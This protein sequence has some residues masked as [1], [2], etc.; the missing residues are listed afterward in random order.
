M[1]L[2]APPALFRHFHRMAWLAALFTASTILFGS[3]VRL[4][5]AGMSC[6]DWPTCYGRVT[7]PQTTNEANTHVA[8]KIRPLESHKAWREQ[9]HRFLAGA[10]GVE[11]LVLSL[12]A[13][14]RRRMGIAQ[15][16]SAAL[17]VALSIPLY[18]SGW[19]SVGLGVAIAG[20][21]ILL[22]AALRWSNIDLARAA[23][24]TLAVVIFQALLG[25]WTVTLLLKPIVVMG[26]LLGG[27]LMFSLL[28]WMAWRATHLPITLA[29]ASRLKWLLRLGVAV[30]GL[31]IALGAGSAPTTPRWRAAAAA[32]RPTISRVASASGG[33]RTISAEA[34]RCGVA[35]GWITKAACL[36]AR[37]ASRSRWRTGCGRLRPRCTYGGWP[38]ACRVR[39]GCGCGLRRLRCWWP[40]R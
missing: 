30:L 23:V 33:R 32:G 13:V 27:M 14:R 19:H 8:S 18:M 15:V 17:L 36:M 20:E 39:R 9:V 34:S 7:W 28:V 5:D 6:P 22:L 38:G 12:L 1:N 24:L 26:H 3:F 11:V 25:M 2:F 31:Q 35:L 10:L 21:A 37:R 4:S 16:V 40:C 29:D